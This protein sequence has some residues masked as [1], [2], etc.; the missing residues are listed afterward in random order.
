MLVPVVVVRLLRPPTRESLDGFMIGALGALCLHR[1]S[2]ADPAGA[3]IRHR[4]D[5]PRPPVSSLIVEAGI[6]GVA[7]PL[8]AAAVGGLIGAALWFTRP[9][10]KTHQHASF[11]RAAAGGL[12]RGGPGRLRRTGTRRRRPHSTDT[13]AGRPSDGRRGSTSSACD[14]VCTLRC[15]MKR[16]TR[17]SPMSRCCVRTATTSSPT[18]RSAR[19]AG[20]PLTRRPGS[21]ER[22]AA[23]RGRRGQAPTHR[24]APRSPAI[25]RPREPTPHRRCTGR[26]IVRLLRTW[27]VAIVV[28]AVALVALSV[29][30]H[31]PPARYVCPPDC[32]HPPTGE[33]VAVNPALHR[34]RRHVLRL[35]SRTECGVQDHHERQWRTRGLPRR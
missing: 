2:D 7:V 32:G 17:S 16:K 4:D 15:C 13:A 9:P 19:R 23:E 24:M 5:R 25:P 30:I 3:A 33:P 28:V 6:R 35:L 27:G 18:W 31:K 1:G 12:R 26:R 11:V 14:S 29:I 8:T 10:S 20:S 21:R 22:S 34:P